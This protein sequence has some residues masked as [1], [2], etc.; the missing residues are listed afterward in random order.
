MNNADPTGYWCSAFINGKFYSHPGYCNGNG[1]NQNYV[2]DNNAVNFGRTIFDASKDKGKWYPKNAF[3]IP[4]DKTGITDA[5]IG[6]V[7]DTNCFNFVTFGTY[8]VVVKTPSL[9]KTTGS[10]IK[11]AWTWAK[12]LVSGT[13]KLKIPQGLTREQF[14]S[15]SSIIKK[16]VGSISS[17]I[18]VQGSRANGTA[19]LSSDIDFAIKVSSKKFDEL[20][21]QRFG[22]PNPGSAK[23]R[24]MQN[25][26]KTGKIQAGE[27]GLRNL[28][29]ELEK[30]LGMEVDISIIKKGGSFD[31]G[32]QILLP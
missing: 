27:A 15:A 13:K 1:P 29:K 10:S 16:N 14:N 25:A 31:N 32:A 26:I 19:K 30:V 7:Y 24:T 11:K 21:K 2:P 23:E 20:I 8:G 22:T 12:N 6:C 28:R 5:A 17:D 3:Y 4:G 18:V 9:V